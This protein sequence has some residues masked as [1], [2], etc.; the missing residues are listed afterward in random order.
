M[1]I[2]MSE[3]IEDTRPFLPLPS[4]I[5]KQG[6]VNIIC[7]EFYLLTTRDAK[8]AQIHLKCETPFPCPDVRFN[9]R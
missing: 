4:T 3:M 7:Q 5:A 8:G 1:Y 2:F 9:L 6:N